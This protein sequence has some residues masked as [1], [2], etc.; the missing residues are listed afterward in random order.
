VCGK[1]TLEA[2]RPRLRQRWEVIR[3]FVPWKRL[4]SDV[5]G[6]RRVVDATMHRA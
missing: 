6:A 4:V 2:L 3:A 1:G 5:S